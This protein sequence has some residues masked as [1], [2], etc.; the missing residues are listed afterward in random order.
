MTPQTAIKQ[1]IY[2]CRPHFKKIDGAVKLAALNEIF[3][4]QPLPSILGGNIAKKKDGRFS[5]WACQPTDIL[6]F[7]AGQKKP[8]ENINNVLAKYKTV[9]NILKDFTSGIF[10]GGW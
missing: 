5:Y 6:E 4:A 8:L 7:H 10:C 1:E 9:Y 3:A 2:H